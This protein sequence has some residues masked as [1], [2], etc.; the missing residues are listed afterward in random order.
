MTRILQLSDPHIV[1]DGQLAYGVVDTA[2]A[3]SDAIDTINRYLPLFGPVDLAIVTGDLTDFGSPGE[4]ARFRAIM[5]ALS[6]PYRVMPGNHDRRENLRQ[7][8]RDQDWMTETG[9][10]VWSA[11]LPDF[12]LIALDTLVEGKH[13][14]NLDGSNLNFLQQELDGFDGKPVIVGMH[15][16]P[17]AAGIIPMDGNN[18]RNGDELRGILDSYPGETRL[19]CGHVHRSVTTLFGSSLALIAP[20]ISHSVTLDQRQESSHTLSLEPGGFMLHEWRDGLVSHIVATRFPTDRYP[21]ATQLA[22]GGGTGVVQY[23]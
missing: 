14:G 21:F 17:F 20:G 12:G 5:E 4:Y 9:A 13:H 23:K 16:P 22:G 15:H 1:P 8:F 6:I 11:D 18:L 19:V 2:T 3:L 10:I 7:A